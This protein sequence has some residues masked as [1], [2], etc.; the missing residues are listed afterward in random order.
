[1]GL[2]EK[3]I[4]SGKLLSPYLTSTCF[5]HNKTRTNEHL[6]SVIGNK[7]LM[8]GM[9][10]FSKV[11]ERSC[12]ILSVLS[13]LPSLLCLKEGVTIPN[14]TTSILLQLE[15]FC[16]KK[17]LVSH[18]SAFSATQPIVMQEGWCKV[19]QKRFADGINPTLPLKDEKA[20]L[21]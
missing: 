21:S 16:T 2:R 11:E 18:E 20:S 4:Q 15:M 10:S 6:Y 17:L 8:L 14:L 19:S 9:K 12:F 5:P 7:L 1:M 13:E 3:G